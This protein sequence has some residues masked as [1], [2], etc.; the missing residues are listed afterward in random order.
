M[1]VKRI[2]NKIADSRLALPVTAI[3]AVLVCLISGFIT[4]H[5]WAQFAILIVSTYM[6]LELNN[7]NALIRIYS[8]MVSC[9][10]LM[11]AVMAHFLLVSVPYGMVQLLFIG[12]LLLFFR[13][14]QD[15]RAAGTVFYA[16]TMLGAA[17]LFFVQVLYFVPIT[18][19]LLRTNIMAGNV[20]TL[21]ASI[22]GLLMP[23]WCVGGYYLYV[24][25]T[26]LFLNHFT[27]LWQ[28]A[29]LADFSILQ[30][31]QMVSLAFIALVDIIR[32]LFEVFTTFSL[33][34]MAFIVLQ[35]Q[36]TNFLLSMLLVCASPMIA[37][38]ISLTHTRI[39][40]II[41]IVLLISVVSIT[42]CNLWLF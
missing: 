15:K 39:T 13:C 8:R 20:R 29:P 24:G 27:Q 26:D 38:F 40:N 33:C 22:I 35:P 28:L 37:H 9:S 11:L 18:W 5:L 6:M 14:Y 34:I 10:Y 25:E 36:H 30:P 16:Y 32:M 42:A 12:F 41:F 4:Q 23:Y 17:S 19:I 3:Y 31:S 21:S 2:Q 1:S 7:T